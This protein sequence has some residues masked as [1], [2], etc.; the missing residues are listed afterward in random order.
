MSADRYVLAGV[1][2]VRSTWFTE[3]SRWATVGSLPIEFVKCVSTVELRARL[4]GGR[5]FSGVLVDGR[6]PA[7][8]R[9][10]LATITSAGSAALVVTGPSDAIDWSSLGASATLAAPFGRSELLDLLVSH[11]QPVDDV[12]HR[13][14]PAADDLTKTIAWRAPLVAVTGRPGAGTSTIA[15]ATAQSLAGDPRTGGDLVLAD[16]ARHAHQAILHDARDVVPGVQELVE[17]HRSGRPTAHDIRSLTFDV[18][19]RGYRLLLGLRRPR[20]WVAIRPQAFAAGLNG[21][22]RSTR[23]LVA[24]VDDDL[25]GEAE[26]GSFDVEERNLLARRTTAEADVVVAVASATATG[27]CGL[28]HQLIDLRA[29]GV[30]GERIVVV[31]NRAPR[32]PRQR[33]ELVRAVADLTG[34]V[35]GLDG[36]PLLGDEPRP[37]VGPVF[38]AERRGVEELHH[39]VARFPDRWTAPVAETVRTVLDGMGPRAH[40]GA[41]GKPVLVTPGSLGHWSEADGPDEATSA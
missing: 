8:D 18:P 16:L 6:L 41:D 30:T 38:V 29:H 2:H 23:L 9:D 5:T 12:E 1:A 17:A 34:G 15:A 21:L 24:D 36:S 40:E 22:R 11:C 3:V 28:A 7:V 27:L 19:G 37:Y 39:D 31:L 10:L 14:G 33:A 26:T 35:V 25:E 20:D 32:R 13:G 4:A